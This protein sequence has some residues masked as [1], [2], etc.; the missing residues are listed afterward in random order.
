M[1]IIFCECE[2]GNVLPVCTLLVT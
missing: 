2:E 1:L